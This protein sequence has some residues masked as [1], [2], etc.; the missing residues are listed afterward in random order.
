[1]PRRPR[2]K[3]RKLAQKNDAKRLVSALSYRDEMSDSHGRLFDFGAGV[4]RDAALALA[5]VAG[6]NGVDVGEALINTLGD[7][8]GEVRR[9][10]AWALGARREER[11]VPALTQAALTWH[12][13]RY[14]AARVAAGEAL[15]ELSGP[16][17]AELVVKEVVHRDD[18]DLE[19]ARPIVTGMVASGGH[20]T[21]KAASAAA[22]DALLRG[23]GHAPGRGAEVLVW[24]GPEH[25]EEL[26]S[27]VQS[28]GDRCVPGIVALGRLRD[29]RA[30]DT[31]TRYLF[32]G[33]PEVRLAAAR[34]LGEIADPRARDA[35]N[36]ATTDGDYDVR[37]AALEAVQKLGM[38]GGSGAS[39]PPAPSRPRQAFT[40]SDFFD[41]DPAPD[42]EPQVDDEPQI[43][44]EPQVHD[45]PEAHEEPEVVA[46]PTVVHEAQPTDVHEAQPT[47]VHE[48]QPAEGEAAPADGGATHA[49]AV[50]AV[51]DTD[52]HSDAEG[53]TDA[54]QAQA[55]ASDAEAPEVQGPDAQAEEMPGA[56]EEAPA[57][58]ESGERQVGT[59]VR[60][61]FRS[62]R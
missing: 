55:Q 58:S 20:P 21:A 26:L 24:L 19:S 22:I 28:S 37:T 12:E 52:A 45:E 18:A 6:S 48:A 50:E 43:D 5:R 30:T 49:A 9:A 46:Q 13:P 8:S 47:V 44:D 2:P 40:G 38:A 11:A 1:M 7:H 16:G 34:A 62:N 35:L 27:A 3:I 31:L 23:Q 57:D 54:P 60:R 15:V 32:D 41:E 36:A 29:L 59:T 53:Q 56:P 14:D 17:S 33:R 42:D 61:W 51:A 4:R 25:T 10:A 39:A